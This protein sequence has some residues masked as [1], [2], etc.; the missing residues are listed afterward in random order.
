[1]HKTLYNMSGGGEVP[2]KTFLFFEGGACVSSKGVPLRSSRS[3]K[4]TDV[5]TNRKLIFDFLLVI[6][7][8]LPPILHRFQVG[9]FFRWRESI[10]SF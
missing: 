8:N 9:P 2:P 3:F 5:R 4:V 7:S 1:M 10:A 6:D